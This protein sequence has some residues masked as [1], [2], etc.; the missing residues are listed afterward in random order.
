MNVSDF[1]VDFDNLQTSHFVTN[2]EEN[3]E[4]QASDQILMFGTIPIKKCENYLLMR[5]MKLKNESALEIRQ[6]RRQI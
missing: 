5:R 4:V 2:P 6:K 3:F 1:D